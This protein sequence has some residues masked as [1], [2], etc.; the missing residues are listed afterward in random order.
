LVYYLLIK[1]FKMETSVNLANY[2][3]GAGFS[4]DALS[5]A[6]QS[7]AELNELSKALEAGSTT[8]RETT[9]LTTASGAPLKVESLEK[10]LKVLTFSE[11]D[12]KMW[13]RIPKSPAF[14]TVEEYLQLDSYGADRGGF[15]N[16]GEL[17][18][19]E[20]STYIRKAELVK[21]LGVTKSVTHPMTLVKNYIGNAVQKEVT[22]GIQWILRKADKGLFRADSNIVSQEWNGLY[23]QHR[24][25]GGYANLDAYQKTNSLVIDMRGKRLSE[26]AIESGCLEIIRN[27]GQANLLVGPPSVLSN[28]V[29]NFHDKKLINPSSVQ[30][31]NG[32]MGQA[33]NRFASQFGEI[34][35][36]YDIFAAKSAPK[37]VNATASS[38]KAPGAVVSVGATTPV[39]VLGQFVAADAGDYIYAVA[40]KNR[41]GESALTQITGGAITVAAGDSVDLEFT[42]GGG[43]YP[44]TGYVIYRSKVDDTA[45]SA[46]LYPLF[47]VSTA[48]LTAGYDGGAAGHVFDNNR[49]LPET[50]EAMLLQS[51]SNIYE[52]KQLAPL[53]KMP[54]AQLSPAQR[55]MVLLY[56]TPILY[57]PKK[58]V[59]FINVGTEA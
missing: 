9:D 41:Y 45:A 25:N 58:V 47:E 42:D 18:E 55:F 33:V 49:W 20:D 17:P 52:F 44:A 19:E 36:D 30:V 48:E 28:F 15:N 35:L 56:G 12:I 16:E 14:N 24:V 4:E 27:F 39:N 53:M 5:Q 32:V 7:A 13:K 37:L 43:A 26:A 11:S 22:N 3:H 54:L 6:P 46:N 51:D 59:R 1:R 57:Q 34:E 29:K 2:G 38:N 23:T 8:G 40:S 50:E 21:F 31:T 10:N